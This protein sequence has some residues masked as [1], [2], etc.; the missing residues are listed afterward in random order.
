M[1]GLRSGVSRAVEVEATA[2]TGGRYRSPARET[3]SFSSKELQSLRGLYVD[4][5]KRLAAID[6]QIK[7]LRLERSDLKE[8]IKALQD[9]LGEHEDAGGVPCAGSVDLGQVA[10]PDWS[11][12]E[13]RWTTTLE[14]CALHFFGIRE[15]RNNQREVMNAVLSGQDAILIMPTGGGK[16]LC[17]QLP[18]LAATASRSL[19]LIV[20]PLVSL[21]A[22]QVRGLRCA[23]NP[24]PW[25]QG[26]V[27]VWSRFL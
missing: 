21:M 12:R 13:F 6:Q 7:Q 9:R 26:T 22:D 18:A 19:T 5:Q 24:T 16:S 20:S 3:L 25:T 17:F 23:N 8:E 2:V 10:E 15:F 14:Y 11:S 1:Q 4:A 27:L